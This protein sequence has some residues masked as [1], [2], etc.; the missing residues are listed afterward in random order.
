L[1][2]WLILG[3]VFGC[4]AFLAIQFSDY[5]C[6]G[7]QAFEDGPKPGRA[8]IWVLIGAGALIGIVAGLRGIEI[9][10][11]VVLCLVVSAI[12][13][14][15]YSDAAKGV[16][17]DYFTLFPL[18]LILVPSIIF[19][20]AGYWNVFWALAAFVP[21]AAASLISKGRG[22]GW[23]DTKLAALGGAVLGDAAL[24]AYSGACL[25]AV[26]VAY[27]R[28]RR[29]EPIA[30]GPY[31]AASIACGVLFQLISKR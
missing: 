3:V 2:T 19:G 20:G 12:V 15:W 14:A 17:P 21:F 5:L 18:A 24:I 25:A 11:A 29:T 22:M 13:A 7:I 26:A 6:R 31:L 4:G 1:P 23:G 27:A 9:V 30:F 16:I 28:K 10:R 8:P